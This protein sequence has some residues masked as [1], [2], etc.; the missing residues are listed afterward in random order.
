ME[1][2]KVAI[3][4][5]VW[6]VNKYLFE[7]LESV[8]KITLNK[9]VIVIDDHGDEDPW[10]IFKHFAHN[11]TF[12]FYKNEKN[13][14]LGFARN[15]GISKISND[16]THVMFVDSDDV[17]RFDIINNLDSVVVGRTLYMTHF[18][19]FTK[20]NSIVKKLPK[21]VGTSITGYVW[22]H[23]WSV[24]VV[25]NL[26]FKSKYYEDMIFSMTAFNLYF[27]KFDFIN[28]PYYM[29]RYRKSSV[30]FRGWDENNLIE[31]IDAVSGLSNNVIEN[32][33]VDDFYWWWLGKQYEFIFK[34]TK[35]SLWK[36]HIS[37]MP[38]IKKLVVWFRFIAIKIQKVTFFE[39]FYSS[40]WK[41]GQYE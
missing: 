8:S 29:Y 13:L 35:R 9:E 41:V 39:Y 2:I 16:V 27:D 38:H 32:D 24:D 33:M 21:L 19:G 7:C 12:F 10:T 5:P 37:K 28:V 6:N 26:S 15:V 1:N 4:I 40:K 14:G 36:K 20:N 11:E 34:K 18:I 31:F 22:G 25:K 23:F 3:I 30:S 17:V